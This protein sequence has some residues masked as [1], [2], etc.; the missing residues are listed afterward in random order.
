MTAQN[1]MS[2][3]IDAMKRGAYDY[4]TKP[5]DL[6]EVCA[7]TQRALE[8]QRLSRDLTRLEHEM[9]RRFELGVEIVGRSAPMQEIYKTI[10]RVAQ[11]E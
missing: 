7:L 5:F 4:V 9:R 6:D 8:R 3:A 11:A 1:T 2:N 10:G